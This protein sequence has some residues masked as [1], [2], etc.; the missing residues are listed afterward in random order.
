MSKSAMLRT[1][2]RD[3][4]VKPNRRLDRKSSRGMIYENEELRLRTININAEIERGQSDIKKL[5]RENEQLRKEIWCLR[6][7]YEKLDKLLKDKDHTSCSSCSSDTDSCTS[8]SES[9][10]NETTQNI[11]NVQKTTLNNLRTEFDHLS[12]V[13]EETSAE[14]SD[15]NSNS[16][17]SLK[18]NMWDAIPPDQSYPNCATLSTS[19]ST[20]PIDQMPKHFFSPIKT[21]RSFENCTGSENLSASSWSLGR[22][23]N[24]NWIPFHHSSNFINFDQNFNTTA[25]T[26]AMKSTLPTLPGLSTNLPTMSATLPA[27][28]RQNPSVILAKPLNA[29]HPPDFTKPT[30]DLKPCKKTSTDII[31]KTDSGCSFPNFSQ[32]S[33]TNS[34]INGGNL[35]EL[36]QDIETISKDIL[37]ISSQGPNTNEVDQNKTP[38]GQIPF[39]NV[40]VDNFEEENDILEDGK[41]GLNGRPY[42]SELNVV[43]MPKPMPL[44]GFDKYQNI[45]SSLESLDGIR[46]STESIPM[47]DIPQVNKVPSIPELPIPENI[48]LQR[49]IPPP[50]FTPQPFP[51]ELLTFTPIP[52]NTIPVSSPTPVSEPLAKKD[53]KNEKAEN[54]KNDDK[55]EAEKKD[56]A[57]KSP[58]SRRTRKV[59]IYFKGKKDKLVRS[60][61]VDTKMMQ[62]KSFDHSDNLKSH[63]FDKSPQME[64]KSMF[65][66]RKNSTTIPKSPGTDSKHSSYE[67]NQS[68]NF[69]VKIDSLDKTQNSDNKTSS[70]SKNSNYDRKH[71]KSS[72]TSPERKHVHVKLE[73]GKKCHKK[74]HRKSERRL[75]NRR[76]SLSIDRGRE[77]S[78]SVCTD[79]SNILDH[80]FGHFEDLTNS[81]RDR[82]NSLSSCDTIKSRKMSGV[83][84]FQVS[85]KIPW[86]GCWGNGCL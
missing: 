72:S 28:G 74:R 41:I 11:E 68:P 86:F 80:K 46:K 55:K 48:P 64:K 39:V 1:R 16:A 45:K 47:L 6:D 8:C 43:L 67:G 36:L 78:F 13:T 7:E 38:N 19:K 82:S 18:E 23:A 77:R 35:E 81:E 63:P 4:N 66:E 53:S 62:N 60:F 20:L 42:K 34:F 25:P 3:V 51:N 32:D 17:V 75:P 79:R 30:I 70:D 44:I 58:K 2:R 29:S 85:G 40:T 49:P 26:G 61:S 84:Q 10:E 59:S 15:K 22:N 27:Q 24:P 52:E 31:V 56:E 21:S 9:E 5:R 83:P 33:S 12:V 69:P 50:S 76:S 14:N 57:Q 71:R 54:E 37:Q 73:D 65:D